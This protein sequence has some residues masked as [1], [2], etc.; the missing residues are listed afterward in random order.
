MSQP[1]TTPVGSRVAS[2]AGPRDQRRW[3]NVALWVLQVVL[4]G[5]FVLAAIPKL[6]ADP[7]AVDGFTALGLGTVGMYLVG[8]LEIAGAIGLLIPP[9]AGLAGLGLVGLMIGA[10]VTTVLMFGADPVVAIPATV[11]VLVGIVAWGRRRRTAELP[12]LMRS[13]LRG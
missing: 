13:R 10:V 4:A 7:Q 2:P 3:G 1:S 8:A 5:V 6:T 9:L 12:A 11:L